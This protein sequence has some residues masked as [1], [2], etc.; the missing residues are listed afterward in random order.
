MSTKRTNPW[1]INPQPNPQATLRLFCLP[2]AGGGI[3]PFRAWSRELPATIDVCLVQLPGRETRLS[4][5]AIN[6]LERLLELLV[7]Q[8]QPWLDRPY[9]VF[10]HSMG[11]VIGFELVRTLMQ[12]GQPA[13][14]HLFVSGRRAPHLPET[15]ALVHMLP[16]AEFV[17]ALQQRYNAIPELILQEPELLAL[18]LPTLRADFTLIE[19]YRYV[20]SPPLP[21]PL[22]VFGGLADPVVTQEELAAWH[23]HT[24]SAFAVRMFPGDHFFLNSTRSAL[25]GAIAHPLIRTTG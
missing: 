11:A 1:V 20:G 25:L 22:T 6:Q 16:D 18:F 12:Q 21:C 10:G 8:M 7:P 9:A 14:A 17:P 19:T 5:P 2:Y 15:R 23:E 24:S 4:E 13:P 3:A